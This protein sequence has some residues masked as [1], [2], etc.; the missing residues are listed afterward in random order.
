ME[1]VE[2]DLGAL[3]AVTVTLTDEEADRVRRLCQRTAVAVEGAALD[4]ER[5][6]TAV[7]LAACDLPPRLVAALAAFRTT[8]NAYGTLAVA[9]LPIDRDLPPTPP[10]GYLP[11]WRDVP[12]ATIAQLAVTA[13]LGDLIAYADEKRGRLVQDVVPVAGAQ[14]RQENSGTVFLELHT[15][16]GFHPYK[17]DHLSLLCLRP[18]PD[19]AGYTLTGAVA[20]VLP[21]LSRVCLETLRRPLF[22]IRH[23]SSFTGAGT[24]GYSPTVAVLSGPLEQPELIADFH[25][26]EP[27]TRGARWAIEE[28]ETVLPTV[29]VGTSLEPGT[30]LAV[31]NRAAV[32]GRTAFTA[33]FDGADRWLR[34][35]F[36]VAD[37]RRSRGS[38]AP[39]S[40]VCA[41]LPEVRAR[42]AAAAPASVPAYGHRAEPAGSAPSSARR[43]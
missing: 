12:V 32:H 41:P 42:L 21:R 36:T 40:R 8:G 4:G 43:G 29:L 10:D 37:L 38:R 19:R 25:A 34:R 16:N 30:L 39:G 6:M 22:R 26:M 13:H 1:S 31:D 15:E 24:A 28:L 9:N 23:S 20:R 14:R 2:F 3:A 7:A 33:R 17:P 35:C 18:D 5:A 27:L 11:D